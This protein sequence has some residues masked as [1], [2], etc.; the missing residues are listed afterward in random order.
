MARKA[1]SLEQ[2]NHIIKKAA[3]IGGKHSNMSTERMYE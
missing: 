1:Y 3:E 2:K